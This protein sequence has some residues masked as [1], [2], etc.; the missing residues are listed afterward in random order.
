MTLDVIIAWITA[1]I[2]FGTVI[3]FG[4]IGET[5]NE[6]AGG[7]NLGTPGIMMLGGIASLAG[8][9][10]YERSTPNPVPIVCVLISLISCLVVSGLAG[11]LYGFLTIT[12]RANQNVTGLTLTIF[13]NGI[14]NF[15]GGSLV[16]LSGG[17]GQI[18][19][20]ATSK[21]FKATMP[22]IS[23][24]LGIVSQLLF[25]YGWLTYV[26]LIMAFAMQYFFNKTRTGLNLRSVGEN[27]ATADAAGINVTKYKYVASCL[28]A[29]ISGL[30]GLYYVMDYVK[31]TWSNDSGIESLGWLAVALVIFTSWKPKNATW[32]AYL[33][34]FCYWIYLYIP[35]GINN[36]LM[37]LFNVSRT[38]Y[39]QNL[40]KMIP[41]I[42]TIIVLV[43]VSSKKKREN[44]APQSL[45]ISYFREER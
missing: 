15:F 23:S 29:A 7:L 19:V 21:A 40:Y 36:A 16:K 22:F 41:Y 35:A 32:G 8:A 4:C 1:A 26:V 31:G 42:V 9:F 2:T 30:G 11:L 24:N 34:G 44:Q 17:V 33:F 3:M 10:F 45:G 27:P 20:A 18:S 43:L 37:K 28:G 39:M 12:L 25:K 13:G 38:T 6:K 5:L 14:A